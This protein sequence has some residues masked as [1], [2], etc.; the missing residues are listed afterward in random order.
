V[1]ILILHGPNLNLLGTRE[2]SLYGRMTLADVQDD[3]DRV[4]ALL[5][6]TLDHRQSNHE[7][8]LVDA[9]QERRFA[10]AVIN[11][12]AYSHTSIAL[13]DALLA[14]ALPFIEVHVSNVWRRE[15]FRHHSMLADVAVGAVVGLGGRGYRL[16]LQGLVEHLRDT[17]GGVS[18][19]GL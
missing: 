10:G 13:R 2:P 4:A 12:G 16:A 5:G 1:R 7:G 9:V 8:V 6:V 17:G 14:T 3:L 19:G 18:S 15:T 11:A